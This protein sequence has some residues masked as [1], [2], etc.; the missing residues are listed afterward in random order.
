[1]TQIITYQTGQRTSFTRNNAHINATRR[2]PS[3]QQR[4]NLLRNCEVTFSA[5]TR[6]HSPQFMVI[7]K[8]SWHDFT[9]HITPKICSQDTALSHRWQ[10]GTTLLTS[11][12]ST[13][14]NPI[15]LIFLLFSQTIT[16][17]KPIF[18]FTSQSTQKEQNT[19]VEV[20]FSATEG[21]LLR[22]NEIPKSSINFN[23][24][25]AWKSLT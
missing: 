10:P 20:T 15:S 8:T 22:N 2:L 1:M 9:P 21:Y 6:L 25:D 13:P 16:P 23:F 11:Q 7:D 5:I 17:E 12:K 24:Y 19:T 4:G 14:Y 18:P 3:S